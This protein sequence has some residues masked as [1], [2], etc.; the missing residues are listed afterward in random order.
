MD[1]L[2]SDKLLLAGAVALTPA[3]QAVAL[4][5]AANAATPANSRTIPQKVSARVIVD[6]DFA[7]DP[8]G[9]VP[10]CDTI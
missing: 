7:G 1:A 8:D 5:T 9:L 10:W 4:T 2:A 3:A 6:N